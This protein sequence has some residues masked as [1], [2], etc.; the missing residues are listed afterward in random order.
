MGILNATP[1]SFSDGGRYTTVD[2]AVACARRFFEQGADIIDIGAESTRPGAPVVDE[3]TEMA[4]LLPV[5]EAVAAS[6]P[7]PISIDTRRAR[8]M[9]AAHALGACMMNDVSALRDDPES[10]RTV[11]ELGL[12]VCLMHRRGTPQTMQGQTHYSDVV[13]DI[14]DF[15][16]ERVRV[17]RAAGI[18]AERIVLD[19]GIG[20]A[21]D[22]EGNLRL[23]HR[24]DA[25]R[26][27]GFPLLIGVSR[28]GF[29]GSLTGVTEPS[30]RDPG[31]VAAALWIWARIGPAI[32][33]VHDVG[34]TVQAL[35]VWAALDAD[36]DPNPK[37]G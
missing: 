13:M 21:K 23:L 30:A 12:D 16:A 27:L 5:V 28:K 7:L 31:S 9:R 34:A 10:L 32:L 2:A 18:A 29:I 20:F 14:R 24:L 11:A 17:C 19:P 37:K 22:L 36:L 25:L 4:R 6:V 8:V 33:R 35:R 26:E 15:L 1:D 3:K